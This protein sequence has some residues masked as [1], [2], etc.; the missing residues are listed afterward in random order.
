MAVSRE[1]EI[2]ESH[3]NVATQNNVYTHSSLKSPC[4]GVLVLMSVYSLVSHLQPV[5]SD[6]E[7]PP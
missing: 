5:I 4:H 1:K 2:S 7:I 6:T 3:R